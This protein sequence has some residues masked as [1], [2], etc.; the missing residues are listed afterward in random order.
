MFL[1]ESHFLQ[2][3]QSFILGK[4]TQN[5]YAD[6]IIDQFKKHGK[7]LDKRLVDEL[8]IWTDVHTFYTQFFCNQLF[9]LF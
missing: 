1:E 9:I 4:L 7:Q 3:Q 5:T 2:I 6:F 8:L